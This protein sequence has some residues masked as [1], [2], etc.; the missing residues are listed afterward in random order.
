MYVGCGYM[1]DGLFKLNVIIVANKT[2]SNDVIV[3]QEASNDVMK[4]RIKDIR[5][6]Y[7]Q[8]KYLGH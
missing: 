3:A 7:K 4:L 5:Y 2:Q 1:Y 6:K 8:V